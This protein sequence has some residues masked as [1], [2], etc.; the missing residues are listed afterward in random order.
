MKTK[1]LVLALCPVMFA[2]VY[3]GSTVLATEDDDACDMKTVVKGYYCESCSEILDKKAL[4]SDVTYYECS[5]CG[6]ISK[7]AG[8]C[9]DCEEDYEKKTSGKDVCPKC[10]DK[11]E[12]VEICVKTCY[13]CPECGD[14]QAEAGTCE[15][16]EKKL[17]ET[18]V[19]ALIEYRCPQKGCYQ[20]SYKPGKCENEECENCG[21]PLVKN[22]SESGVFPHVKEKAKKP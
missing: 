7:T 19:R 17:V 1:L 2:A 12:D 15:D 13:E 4:V 6:L 18:T 5:F 3:V 11:P 8:K 16:C 14:Q 22:C 10:Y 21:K 20:T 9:P